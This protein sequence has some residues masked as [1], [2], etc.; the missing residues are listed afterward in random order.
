MIKLLNLSCLC[1]LFIHLKMD[2]KTPMDRIRTHLCLQIYNSTILCKKIAGKLMA[3][4][5]EFYCASCKSLLIALHVLWAYYWTYWYIFSCKNL[6]ATFCILLDKFWKFLCLLVF[7]NYDQVL[8]VSSWQ[9][10]EFYSSVII[11]ESY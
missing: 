6:W 2:T 9:S 8:S 11:L 4:Q 3:I 10:I 1:G 5:L 7:R